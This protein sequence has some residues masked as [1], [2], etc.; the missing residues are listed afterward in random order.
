MIVA[1]DR[2]L[3]ALS[4]ALDRVCAVTAFIAL[5]VMLLSVLLQ[6]VARYIF[7]APPAWTEELARYAMIWSAMTGAAMAYYRGADPVMMRFDT[8]GLPG[9][10]LFMLSIEAVAVLTLAAPVFYYAPGFMA[11]HS[12]RITETLE[13]NSAAVVVIIPASFGVIVV[14]LAARYARALRNFLLGDAPR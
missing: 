14:H 6:I 10:T 3:R 5:H 2:G 9:R 12:H 4:R 8:R 7:N 13:W 1:I 11:R